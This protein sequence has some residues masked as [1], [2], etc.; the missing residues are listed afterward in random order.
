[1]SKIEGMVCDGC[2]SVC[3]TLEGDWER[4]VCYINV[5]EFDRVRGGKKEKYHLCQNECVS[6]QFEEDESDQTVD[7]YWA[8]DRDE[9]RISGARWHRHRPYIQDP[10]SGK[11]TRDEFPDD[12]EEMATTIEELIFDG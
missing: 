11:G 9:G 3:K 12:I 5:R 1:M 4:S 10:D 8:F 7:V 2:G 6:P